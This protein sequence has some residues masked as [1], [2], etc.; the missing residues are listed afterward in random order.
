MK[1][2]QR[3]FIIGAWV[4][5]FFAVLFALPALLDAMP[6]WQGVLVVSLCVLLSLWLWLRGSGRLGVDMRVELEQWMKTPSR[7]EAYDSRRL[8]EDADT[9]SDGDI[10]AGGPARWR[11]R[12]YLSNGRRYSTSVSQ[13]KKAPFIRALR[14]VFPQIKCRRRRR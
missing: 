3:Q 1:D 7:L 14:V 6:V 12:F 5:V 11:I 9:T 13:R 4:S 10:V 8:E 2:H